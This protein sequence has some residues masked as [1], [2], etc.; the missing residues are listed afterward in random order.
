MANPA[1]SSLLERNDVLSA[2]HR[3]L[4][5]ARAGTGAALFIVGAPGLGKSCLLEA[6]VAAAGTMDV[7]LGRGEEMERVVPFGLLEQALSSLDR[8][9]GLALTGGP[10]VADPTA[11]YYRVLRWLERRAQPLLVAL[12]D[13]HWAD[14]DSL[15][16]VAFLARRRSWLPVALIGTSRPWP[17]AAEQL[18]DGLVRSGYAELERLEPL[19]P[20]AVATL[21]AARSK[22]EVPADAAQRAWELCGGNPLLVEQLGTGL[23]RGEPIPRLGGDHRAFAEHLLLTR[24]AGLDDRAWRV[25]RAASI[26]GTRFRFYIAAELAGLDEA[27]GERALESL[28]RAGLVVEHEA[29][30]TRFVHPL[31][32][33]ALY[34]D[35]AA[36]TRQRM[37]ARAFSLLLAGGFDAQAAE[38]AIRADLAGDDQA[39][40]VLERTGRAALASGAVATAADNLAA[41]VRFSG[42]EPAPG[43]VLSLVQALSANGRMEEVAAE[44]DGMLS[45]ASLSWQD[46]IE[47]LRML[48]RAQYLTGAADH[49]DGALDEAVSIAMA[50]DP[51]Q[52]VWSL[53]DKSLTTW[54]DGGPARA[55]PIAAQAREL[56]A[57]GDADLRETAEATWGH[58]ALEAGD[59]AGLT[60]TDP[61]AQ[62]LDEPHRSPAFG[63]TELVWPWAR[64]YQFGMNANYAERYDD[65]ERAF[66][67]ARGVADEAGAASA[68][69]NVS[70]HLASLMIRRGRLQQALGEAVRA[71]ELADLT[72]GVLAYAELVEA[73]ARL[74]LG[75]REASDEVLARALARGS[76]QWFVRLWSAHIRGLRLLWDGDAAASDELLVAEEVTR[77][78]GIREPCNTLWAG[79]AIDAHLAADRPERAARVIAW[80]EE[81]AQPLECRWPRIQ[82]ALGH[83]RMAWHA[84]DS[85]AALAGFERALELEDGH[86]LPLSR[87]ETLLAYGRFLR[88]HARPA[89]ARSPIAEAL[90]AAEAVG[91]APLASI[92]ASE[93]RLAGGKRR[94]G[95]HS[96]DELTDAERRIA[97]LAADGHSNADIARRLYVSV[98]TVQTHLK[99]VYRK[100]GLTSRRQLM[101]QRSHAAQLGEAAPP[102]G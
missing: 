7:G 6:A 21:L 86:R 39:I 40:A 37:H 92:A 22:T 10:P 9:G 96:R 83:A 60:A 101:L 23:A 75:Q 84:G 38:H 8:D 54:L 59:P 102:V 89:D 19:G 12:D 51:V 72:P 30:W 17:A 53:L 33:Q 87:I 66:S 97:D 47:A 69:A 45:R 31:F 28:G 88:T 41:A 18:C 20:P 61:L 67:V 80:L 13:L 36:P 90:A 46:R 57:G 91:A 85:T 98:N 55:L 99:H 65:C 78:V 14:E 26:L 5:Q 56:A 94:R 3:C 44:C 82:V 42:E 71:S 16:M 49:G 68:I 79:N 52:A 11:P 43:L 15:R 73:E 62:H 48:G 93:L 29:S 2:V 24:F 81:C 100:L 64:M 25:A 77:E 50:N 58:L 95:R 1:E 27:D 35:I 32:G 34:G 70:I 63:L 74:W 76:G 4:D